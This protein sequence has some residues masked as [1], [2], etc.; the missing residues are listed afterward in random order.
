M[1]LSG[2]VQDVAKRVA[3]SSLY[4][5]MQDLAKQVT[6]THTHTHVCFMVGSIYV[7]VVVIIPGP[8]CAGGVFR[9]WL[10]WTERNEDHYTWE[11][12]TGLLN[13][14]ATL[15]PLFSQFLADVSL[16]CLLCICVIKELPSLFGKNMPKESKSKYVCPFSSQPELFHHT[17][18]L[19][20][21]FM[22]Q[23]VCVP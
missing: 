5:S 7:Y 9:S 17:H 20:K 23:F 6:H 16:T 10:E 18:N 19:T 3:N 22:W 1:H 8:L 12:K 13:Q 14:D 2:R 4:G 21:C 15:D 11:G